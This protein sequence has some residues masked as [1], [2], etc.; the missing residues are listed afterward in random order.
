MCLLIMTITAT[1]ALLLPSAGLRAETLCVAQTDGD[2]GRET[3]ESTPLAEYQQLPTSL[4]CTSNGKA[5]RDYGFSEKRWAGEEGYLHP[6]FRDQ[7][8]KIL[9]S[10]QKKESPYLRDKIFSALDSQNPRIVSVTLYEDDVMQTEEF[11]GKVVC[12]FK[13]SIF[14]IWTNDFNN[15]VWQG[16]IDLKHRKVVISQVFRGITSVGGEL[17]T[18]DCH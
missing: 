5:M 7:Q 2:H 14:V 16:V 6:I 8:F 1:I 13:D 4:T 15:K 11:I 10:R 12:R 9:T 18:L 3:A 17:E